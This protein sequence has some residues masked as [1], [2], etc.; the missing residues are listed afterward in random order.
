MIGAGMTKGSAPMGLYEDRVLPHVINVLMGTKMQRPIRSRVCAG[1][2]GDVVEIGFGTGHNLPF[3]PDTVTRLRAVEPSST[4]LRLAQQRI[5]DAKFPVEIVGLDG[6]QVPLEDDSADAVLTTWTLCTIPD[7]GA[8]LK[9]MARVLRPGGTLH[10]V[11]HGRAPDENVR[12]W[13]NRFNPVQQRLFGGCN[14]NR[15][16]TGLIEGAGFTV[17]SLET[18]YV[19]GPKALGS[20]YEG[21]AQAA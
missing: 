19:E 9:E 10:F 17:K 12:R 3:L 5:A 8:A 20:M 2:E 15:D 4:S 1:L 16:I 7:A 13:Q 21:T 18:Y 6:Q 14:I 11:E